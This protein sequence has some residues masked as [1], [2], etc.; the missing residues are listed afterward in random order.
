MEKR[1]DVRIPTVNTLLL[2]Q[3]ADESAKTGI[4]ESRLL[5]QYA[6][7][8]VEMSRGGMLPLLAPGVTMAAQTPNTHGQKET[9]D[10]G[11]AL[12]PSLDSAS[13]DSM[14]GDPD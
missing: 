13:L 14:F 9:Q 7:R 5:V 8:Y 3:L 12:Q 11:L 1:F 6:T 2:E 10:K 4:V